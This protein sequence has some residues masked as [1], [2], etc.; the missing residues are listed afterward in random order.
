[1]SNYIIV[2]AIGMALLMTLVFYGNFSTRGG[3]TGVIVAFLLIFMASW[4]SQLWIRPI[5]PVT[6]GI[7]WI[8]LIFTGSAAAFLLAWT[9]LATADTASPAPKEDD[10][11]TRNFFEA[12]GFVFWALVLLLLAAIVLG[13][14][15]PGRDTGLAFFPSK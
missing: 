3:G 6:A 4:A 12:M 1:M 5:G 14:Y 7:V 11:E 2:A 10:K 13:Y 8:P 15:F 9:G